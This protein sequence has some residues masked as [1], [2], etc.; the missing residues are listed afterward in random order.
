ME[1]E[2]PR[3]ES[4][5]RLQR[6]TGFS[7]QDKRYWGFKSSG[8]MSTYLGPDCR[9]YEVKRHR[10]MLKDGR[11]ATSPDSENRSVRSIH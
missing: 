5:E 9:L 10:P 8:A 7:I 11:E 6:T 1:R 4:R 3:C 2:S